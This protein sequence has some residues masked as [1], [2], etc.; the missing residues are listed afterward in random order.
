MGRSVQNPTLASINALVR[1]L[2]PLSSAGKAHAEI[3]RSLARQID[4]ARGRS[5]G[6]MAQ[7]VPSLAREL[8]K[9]IVELLKEKEDDDSFLTWLN[10][11]EDGNDIRN[12]KRA[13]Q[14]AGK[15]LRQA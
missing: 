15:A 10:T 3:A 9:F 4:D 8:G 14:I 6:A 5:S 7:A 1:D 11:D 2:P 12:I 13:K